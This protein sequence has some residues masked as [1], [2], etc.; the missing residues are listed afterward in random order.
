MHSLLSVYKT[1]SLPTI[2]RHGNTERI[3]CA[4][5]GRFNTDKCT[6]MEKNKKQQFVLRRR[7][8]SG[9]AFLFFVFLIIIWINHDLNIE[10][11]LFLLTVLQET[12]A[13]VSLAAHL[14]LIWLF[15]K[16]RNS[17]KWARFRDS[18]FSLLWRN[19]ANMLIQCC[20][21]ARYKVAANVVRL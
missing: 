20:V 10:E 17:Y 8:D 9:T 2:T 11:L 7:L 16:K 18:T 14:R 12:V 15:K 19:I 13:H 6:K 3:P 1:I 21:C 5:R 4:L